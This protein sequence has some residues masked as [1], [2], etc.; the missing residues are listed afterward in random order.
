MGIDKNCLALHEDYYVK[1]EKLMQYSSLEQLQNLKQNGW[2][3]LKQE[4]FLVFWEYLCYR[5]DTA[6]YNDAHSVQTADVA[7]Q[8]VPVTQKTCTLM[9]W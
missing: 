4:S 1:T 9:K 5:N 7:E 2:K 8:T 3:Y 6:K